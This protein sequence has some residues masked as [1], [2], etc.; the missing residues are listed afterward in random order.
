MKVSG[1]DIDPQILNSL[2]SNNLVVFAGSVVSMGPPYNLDNFVTLAKKI[3]ERTDLEF[4]DKDKNYPEVYL[5]SNIPFTT[6]W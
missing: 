5:Q 4:T 6:L 3:G 1:V 2:E